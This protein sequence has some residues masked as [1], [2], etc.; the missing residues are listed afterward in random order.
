MFAVINCCVSS[1]WKAVLFRK[2]VDEIINLLN[3]GG[4]VSIISTDSMTSRREVNMIPKG[5]TK[6]V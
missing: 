5:V 3:N 6:V 2:N 4:L 1:I